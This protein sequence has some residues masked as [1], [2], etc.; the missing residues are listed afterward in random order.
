MR[1]N[2]CLR[3]CMPAHEYSQLPVRWKAADAGD[4][5]TGGTSLRRV[6]Y[7]ESTPQALPFPRHR[8]LRRL[9]L[10]INSVLI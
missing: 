1:L 10:H 2:A 5:S 7:S 8:F 3:V 9:P 4:Y 6:P